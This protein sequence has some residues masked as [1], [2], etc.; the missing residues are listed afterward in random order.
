MKCNVHLRPNFFSVNVSVLAAAF[1]LQ[2]EK[3]PTILPE[4]VG[5]LKVVR[6]MQKLTRKYL[7]KN[8]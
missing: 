3:T 4:I 8:N 7:H 6:R 1:R 5:F 2:K